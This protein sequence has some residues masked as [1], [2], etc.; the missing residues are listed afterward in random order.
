MEE[1]FG[2]QRKKSRVGILGVK[3][4][5][6]YGWGEGD[7]LSYIRIDKWLLDLVIR[8]GQKLFGGL[9][10]GKGKEVKRINVNSVFKMLGWKEGEGKVVKVKMGEVFIEQKEL[11][12]GGFEE[13]WQKEEKGQN[14]CQA[15]QNFF[16]LSVNREEVKDG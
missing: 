14:R 5:E 12:E 1:E 13:V 10:G 9:V 8:K 16:F 2:Q 11:R 15:I 6:F 3:Y 4:E 7:K